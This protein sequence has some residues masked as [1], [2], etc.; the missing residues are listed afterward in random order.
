LDRLPRAL[1]G[2]QRQR[3]ALGRALVRDP[4]VFLFDE[5][6]SNLDARLRIETRAEI[7]E[8]HRRTRAT[9]VYVT[10]D[11]E[12]AMTLADRMVVMR[13]GTVH[14]AGTPEEC[15]ARPADRFVAGFVGM[16]VMNFVEGR[17]E[18]GAFVG[19]G[20]RLGLPAG[21]WPAVPAGPLV[22]GVRPD[23][24]AVAPGAS[25][26]GEA[27]PAAVRAIERL[28]DRMDV[29]LDAAGTRLVARIGNDDRLREGEAAV[30]NSNTA[31]VSG[32]PGDASSGAGVV[33]GVELK[34]PLALIGYVSGDLRVCAFISSGDHTFMSNQA[35]GGCPVG[36]ENAATDVMAALRR[37]IDALGREP[38]SA[39]RDARMALRRTAFDLLFHG[40]TDLG[41][42]VGPV[43]GLRLAALRAEVDARLS[44]PRREG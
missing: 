4:Q 8:M 26:G 21:R 29:V 6:L 25:P 41:A 39:T 42:Q 9:M 35:L 7:R 33:T 15:Y 32:G 20:L 27:L 44:M 19:G 37:E 14:Q 43:A 13:S 17:V 40:G 12:E 31:G 10:H 1:S 18:S 23:R 3:V 22:L 36:T 2:G 28:G 11:Q 24:I 5:P 30:N 38:A 34:I 16:P